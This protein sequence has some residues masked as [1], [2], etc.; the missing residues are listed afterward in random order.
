LDLKGEHM[1]KFMLATV[2]VVSLSS[3]VYAGGVLR[4]FIDP[5]SVVCYACAYS[6]S[7]SMTYVPCNMIPF[8]RL[9]I[10]N[11]EQGSTFS[12]YLVPMKDTER[13][14]IRLKILE[15]YGSVS[16]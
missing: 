13:E 6:D 7:R 3:A 8:D 15:K 16:E 2:M 5:D 4:Y 12:F 11:Q 1:R 14:S 9:F 10:Q